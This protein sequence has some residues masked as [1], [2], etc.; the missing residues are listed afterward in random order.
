MILLASCGLRITAYAQEG[1]G[2]MKKAVMIIPADA[3]R[4]EELLKPK[5]ALEKGGVEVKVASTTLGEVK[6][7]LGSKVK[8]DMLLGDIDIKNFDAVIFVGGSGA[9]QYWDDPLAQQLARD[10]FN[11]KRIVAAICIAPVTLANAGILKGRSATVYS[12][13][14]GLL[15]AKGAKYTAKPVERDGNIITASGPAA[16]EEFAAELLKSLK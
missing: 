6:G 8:P 7:M 1:A 4:D 3:Y 9:N 15:T 2:I 16:A 13:E 11:D 14:A 12:S 5:A 10:A